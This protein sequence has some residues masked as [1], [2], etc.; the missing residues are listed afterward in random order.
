MID[1]FKAYDQEKKDQFLQ[2]ILDPDIE[3]QGLKHPSSISNFRR[4][5]QNVF[6]LLS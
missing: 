3:I 1:T 2:V 6:S 5:V 4:E